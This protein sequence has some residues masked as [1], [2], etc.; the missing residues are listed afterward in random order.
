MVQ[1]QGGR[2]VG[3]AGLQRRQDFQMI[4]DRAVHLIHGVIQV[5]D[6]E[7][8]DF[9]RFLSELGYPARSESENPAYRLFLK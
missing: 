8:E 2:L 6:Q 7:M 9:Q 5:P 1:H 4:V 3:I